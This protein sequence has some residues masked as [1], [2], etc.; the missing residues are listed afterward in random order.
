MLQS[1]FS[2]SGDDSATLGDDALHHFQRANP[3]ARAGTDDSAMPCNA[4]Y[5][6]DY[7]KA[8][9]TGGGGGDHS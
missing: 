5:Y 3:S 4:D 6:A 9:Q 1:N 8:E 7:W 2:T